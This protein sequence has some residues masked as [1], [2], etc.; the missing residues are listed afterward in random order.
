MASNYGQQTA[1]DDVDMTGS[2]TGTSPSG[3]TMTVVLRGFNPDLGGEL[4]DFA[5]KSTIIRY[6]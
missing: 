4:A 6:P 3:A 2:D 1:V 5:A